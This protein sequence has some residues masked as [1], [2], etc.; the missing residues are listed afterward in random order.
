MR[1]SWMQ[2]TPSQWLGLDPLFG[3]ALATELLVLIAP[4]L[5]QVY[6]QTKVASGIC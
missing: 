4:A 3:Q 6:W 2:R 5:S 1:L